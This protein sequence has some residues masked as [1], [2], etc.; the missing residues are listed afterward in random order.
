MHNVVKGRLLL[1]NVILTYCFHAGKLSNNNV[2]VE[3]LPGHLGMP[4]CGLGAMLEQV[5]KC[6]CTVVFS[7]GNGSTILTHACISCRLLVALS[8]MLVCTVVELAGFFSGLSKLNDV[9]Y[10]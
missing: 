8:L 4:P 10:L 3:H 1:V 6:K 2:H 5:Y 9:K 7:E